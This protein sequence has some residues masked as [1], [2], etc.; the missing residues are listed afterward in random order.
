ME[1][2]KL[3]QAQQL[4]EG[5]AIRTGL[6]GTGDDPQ[7]RYLWTDA[8][9]VHTFFGL[10]RILN[11]EAY[12]QQALQLI[13]LVHEHL[14]KY[15][16]QDPRRGPMRGLNENKG[17]A[18]P[19]VS[20]LR[21]G[22]QL[23]ERQKDESYN[24]RLEWDRDGQYFHYLSR[25][26][27][28]LLQAEKETEET[29][30]LFQARDLFLATE[31]F[32]YGSGTGLA[33][34]W[35]MNTDL[36]RP[37]VASMGAHDPLEGLLCGLSLKNALPGKDKEVEALI[38][39]FEIMCRGKT[40]TTLDPLGIGGLL[41]N[42]VRAAQMEAAGMVLPAS[43]K[44]KKL[45][46]ESIDSLS[47]LERFDEDKDPNQR[48]AFRECGL[49]LGLRVAGAPKNA[50]FESSSV[51]MLKKYISLASNIEEYWLNSSHRKAATWKD[52][53]DINSVSLASSLVA[54]KAPEAFSSG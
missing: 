44:S 19:T 30:Y 39:K 49:S 41:L 50:I 36:S 4:M 46:Q 43:V 31:N 34:Y 37:L 53:L 3:Q 14:G 16:P 5:F 20:G 11:D 35:K 48:L 1:N 17:R 23:P 33:M 52:H 26:I 22:K 12:R 7:R 38:E 32:I 29:E 42:L 2:D 45:L 54:L 21:I 47:A 15:H 8:F 13:H 28:A 51:E 6:L 40:W 9:A 10:H 25:W 24:S 27:N 18:R